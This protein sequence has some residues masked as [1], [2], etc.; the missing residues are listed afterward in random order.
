[1]RL[2]EFGD[3][4]GTSII[5]RN[6]SFALGTKI[7]K[8]RFLRLADTQVREPELD[9]LCQFCRPMQT[10]ARR[11]FEVDIPDVVRARV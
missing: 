1:M 8:A 4:R 6:D 11:P 2:L 7:C 3:K 9:S 5:L 10:N